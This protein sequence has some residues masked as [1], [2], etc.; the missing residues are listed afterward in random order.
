LFQFGN[1]LAEVRGRSFT[2]LFGVPLP[3]VLG[4]TNA[5]T[6]R[7]VNLSLPTGVR[8]FARVEPGEA[9]ER[10]RVSMVCVEGASQSP[11]EAARA[12]PSPVPGRADSQSVTLDTLSIGDPQIAETVRRL[13]RVL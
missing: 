9:L 13:R 1:T 8:V 5:R 10:V 11:R 7:C 12:R 4:S 2:Q 3:A 6:N